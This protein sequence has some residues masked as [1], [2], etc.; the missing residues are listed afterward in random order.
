MGNLDDG[1]VA[2]RDGQFMLALN[3]AALADLDGFRAEMDA[4]IDEIHA[5]DRAPG[6]ERLFHAGE[7]E[8]ETLARYRSEGIPLNE[9]TLADL[10]AAARDLGVGVPELD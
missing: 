10:R 2:G 8:A 9:A 4:I 7:V 1:P 6:V 5:S 3:V